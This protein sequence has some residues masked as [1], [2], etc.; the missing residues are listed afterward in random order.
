MLFVVP[1][2]TASLAGVDANLACQCLWFVST[3][4]SWEGAMNLSASAGLRIDRLRVW[5]ENK[6]EFQGVT[7]LTKYHG[8]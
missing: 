1:Q 8:T 7:P 5:T 6:K 4:K 2:D 3:V